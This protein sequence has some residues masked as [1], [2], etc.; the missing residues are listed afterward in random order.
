MQ[1][2]PAADDGGV[3]I[4]NW[5]DERVRA[6]ADMTRGRIFRYGLTPEADLWADEIAEHGYGGHSFPLP[7]PAA[8]PAA[9]RDRCTCGCRCWAPQRAYGAA[10]RGRALVE[11]LGWEEIVA[12]LQSVPGQLRLVVVAGINGCTVIDDTYNA[13]P[14]STIA[15][16]NLLADLAAE[17][18]RSPRRR[19]GRHARAGR[20]IPTKGTSLVGRRAA[21][22]VDV[23]V[24]VARSGRWPSRPRR[25][26]SG[27]TPADLMSTGCTGAI[28]SLCWSQHRC[29]R[30]TW[31]WSRAAGRSGW[32]RLSVGVAWSRAL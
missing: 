5:D 8:G 6:M 11:G 3:A 23:L 12:G 24:T 26:R 13:S 28:P 17:G 22:V 30:T 9:H 1:A 27:L 16:L 31:C 10:C 18:Q 15:A 4:L 2:L 21:D 29:S 25:R 20:A 7:L 14:A 19:V 32:R